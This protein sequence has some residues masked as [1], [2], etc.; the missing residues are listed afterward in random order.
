MRKVIIQLAFILSCSSHIFAQSLNS[1]NRFER[2][3]GFTYGFGLGA[4]ALR[5]NSND[6]VKTSF[7]ATLPN[8]K[9]G[10][11][12]NEK[13]AVNLLLPGTLYKHEGEYRGF[14]GFVLTGQ[15]WVK[16]KWWVLGGTGLTMDA[17]A[18]WRAFKNFNSSDFHKGFP[19]LTFGTGYEIY[20][21]ENFVL[22]VHYRLYTGSVKLE[23]DEKRKGTGHMLVLGFNWY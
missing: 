13:F 20:R 17:P 21:K 6:T 2:K 16:D 18:F 19:A 22:D 1:S 10:Y 9:I 4:G 5:I 15:Y 12:F 14:E 23:N 11:V 3:K 8:I 7:A